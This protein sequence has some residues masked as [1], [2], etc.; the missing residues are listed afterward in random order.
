MTKPDKNLETSSQLNEKNA[1]PNKHL[2]ITYQPNQKKYVEKKMF[3]LRRK[4][5]YSKYEKPNLHISRGYWT[6]SDH[7]KFLDG[8]Y[9]YDCDWKKIQS[10]IKNRTYGQ[11]RSHAQK[12]YLKLKTFK[13]EELGLDFT[14]PNVKNLSDVIKIIKEKEL[15]S[16]NYAKLLHIISKQLS[17]GKNIFPKEQKSSANVA[18]TNQPNNNESKNNNIYYFNNVYNINNINNN[19]QMNYQELMDYTRRMNELFLNSLLID[20]LLINNILSGQYL[21]NNIFV[22]NQQSNGMNGPFGSNMFGKGY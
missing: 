13:D 18:Q 11:V 7:K 12:F 6:K 21:D 1:R 10:Y 5:D 2:F 4:K 9:L 17:F 14:T 8:L 20:K 3:K 15:N 22:N 19:M 16:K